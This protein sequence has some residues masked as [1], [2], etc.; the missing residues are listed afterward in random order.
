MYHY[1]IVKV[2][3]LSLLNDDLL[4]SLFAHF[5]INGKKKGIQITLI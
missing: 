2:S 4:I 1:V 5:N 3:R